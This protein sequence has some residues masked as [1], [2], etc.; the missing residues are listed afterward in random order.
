MNETGTLNCNVVYLDY[1]ATSPLA[2]EVLEAVNVALRDA[3][4]NPSSGHHAGNLNI[5]K[6]MKINCKKIRN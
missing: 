3:W 4:G 6:L 1:N 5:N 2:P